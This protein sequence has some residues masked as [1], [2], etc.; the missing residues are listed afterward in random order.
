MR[1]K[2]LEDRITATKQKSEGAHHARMEKLEALCA[3][4]ESRLKKVE[5]V[6]ME[7]HANMIRVSTPPL[8]EPL[9]PKQ[10]VTKKFGGRPQP[11]LASSGLEK[12]MVV[13][14]SS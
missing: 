6:L 3:A 5:D 14:A 11:K 12:Y 1:Q 10:K 4:Q 2:E 9:T 7:L 8:L 13:E